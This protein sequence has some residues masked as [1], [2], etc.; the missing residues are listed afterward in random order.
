M[1]GKLFDRYLFLYYSWFV[2][3]ALWGLIWEVYTV[4]IMYLGSPSF[5]LG[6]RGVPLALIF[7]IS[8]LRIRH[9]YQSRTET[10]SRSFYPRWLRSQLSVTDTPMW[11][12]G[13]WL[14][15]PRT[16][17]K[18]PARF[19]EYPWDPEYSPRSIIKTWLPDFLVI[20]L[21]LVWFSL[22]SSLLL[23]FARKISIRY[24]TESLD[25]MLQFFKILNAG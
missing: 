4:S 17:S 5:R 1:S 24:W 11:Q 16:H 7:W 19:Q 15:W 6:P 3:S 12:N 25:A 22:C 9:G 14:Q 18:V 20:F 23:G 8:F 2:L 21:Y 13:H 10:C